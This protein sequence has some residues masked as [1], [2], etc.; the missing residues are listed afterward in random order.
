MFRNSTIVLLVLISIS[1]SASPVLQMNKAFIALSDLIPYI[2]DRDKFMDK[3]NE[4]MIGE[5]ISELQS[6]FRS[7]KHDTAIKED[8]FAPSYALINENISGNLEAFKSGKKDY[9]RWRLKEVTPLCLDCHT[10]LPTSHA[11]S[12]QSGELTID[13]SKFENVYNLGIAQLIVRRYADAKDSFIRSIQDKLIKQEMAEMILPFKQ[14]MLIEAKVLKSP[15]NLT[16]FFNE[17]VNKKNLPE[18]VRSSVVEWAKRVEHWKGNKLLSEGLKD[19]KIVKAFIEK[20]LAPLK[21]KAFYSGGYDVDLLI[22]SGLL[23]NYFFENPTSP[24]APEINFWLG[25]SEKYLKRENFFGSGD[26]FLKQCI[27]R[28]PANPVAR[29]CLDEYKDSVE[30]EFSGSGG[31]N[32]PKDIQNELD[33][34]E[35]IIKTK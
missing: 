34:L 30:F 4:K 20:E 6:A 1:I 2:T 19:D 14:V 24:L 25:W 10:R 16:A 31:T 8:L 33:G 23:S 18:D 27:K 7:A 9:A 21:K 3:K 32:I 28:Y 22:A 35:K 5:R 13:K 17:Y 12:F 15:E 29:M 11:S 26:L